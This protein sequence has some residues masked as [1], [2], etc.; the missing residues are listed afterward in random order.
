[1]TSQL[2]AGF[3]VSSWNALAAPGRTPREVLLRLNREVHKALEAPEVQR[4]LAE[5]QWQALAD[6]RGI[7]SAV[8][9]LPGLYGP[10]RP[11]Q[12]PGGPLAHD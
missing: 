9:R 4:R 3:Q 2:F 11:G 6:A 7:A 10:G 1:M 8:F 5:T 12:H